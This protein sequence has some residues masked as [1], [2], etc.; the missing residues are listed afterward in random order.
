MQL[1]CVL[2]TLFSLAA[3]SPALG[4]DSETLLQMMP[5]YISGGIGDEELDLFSDPY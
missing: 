1:H 3:V 5:R 2:A 4:S